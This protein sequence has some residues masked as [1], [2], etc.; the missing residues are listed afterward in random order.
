MQTTCV[1]RT[2]RYKILNLL[3]EDAGAGS[4]QEQADQ[5]RTAVHQA[6]PTRRFG[7]GILQVGVLS[8]GELLVLAK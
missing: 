3:A 6:L 1:S 5:E 4:E 2:P 8:E 7:P